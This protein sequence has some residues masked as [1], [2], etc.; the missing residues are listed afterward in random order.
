MRYYN[1]ILNDDSTYPNYYN[2]FVL[3]E[4]ND[5]DFNITGYYTYTVY[6]QSS[7]TNT[8]PENAGRVLEVGRMRV[9]PES[10]LIEQ[11]FYSEGWSS[12]EIYNYSS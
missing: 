7:P 8:D 10:E 5:V 6:E 1:V 9:Y 4:P 3:D 2:Q 12:N 11:D